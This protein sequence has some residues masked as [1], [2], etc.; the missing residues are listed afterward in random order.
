MPEKKTKVA[1]R[2]T[3]QEIAAL[4][5]RI[6]DI[7]EIQ[8]EIVFKIVAYRRAADAIEHLG[9]DIRTI[10]QNDPKNLRT[11]QGVGEAIAD[12]IDELLRTGEL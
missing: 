9:R 12:K 2:W 3:N 6:G 5:Y 10:W 8:G 4:L 1:P 7:L 11:I